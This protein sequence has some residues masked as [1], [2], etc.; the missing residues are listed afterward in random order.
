MTDLQTL[1]SPALT[2][3]FLP[4]DMHDDTALPSTMKTTPSPPLLPL[5]TLPAMSMPSSLLH[6]A[7][8]LL[9]ATL[10]AAAC[11]LTSKHQH[12]AV[13]SPTSTGKAVT[14]NNNSSTPGS[15]S[16]TAVRSSWSS[17]NTM[18][19]HE[20]L[21]KNG[22]GEANPENNLSHHSSYDKVVLIQVRSPTGI[23]DREE[24]SFPRSLSTTLVRPFWIGRAN[25][26]AHANCCR[27]RR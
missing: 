19:A 25:L 7:M 1:H 22:R 16:T 24:S 17:D 3:L 26:E 21:L 27:T 12:G 20:N 23:E 15:L 18:E 4:H 14:D 2:S 8:S 5:A 13:T 9:Q 11:L 6:V 10:Y